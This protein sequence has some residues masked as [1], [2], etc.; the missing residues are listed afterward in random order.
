MVTAGCPARRAVSRCI[1]PEEG[2]VDW[3]D[4]CATL[5][6]S[7]TFCKGPELASAIETSTS[8]GVPLYRSLQRR[9]LAV[10]CG[11]I[12]SGGFDRLYTSGQLYKGGHC[13]TIG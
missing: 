5:E 13:G 10:E 11:A 8:E 9:D 4:S 1:G 12:I 3:V 7:V 6:L 2:R